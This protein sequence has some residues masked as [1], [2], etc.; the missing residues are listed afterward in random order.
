[1]QPEGLAATE[2]H[3]THKPQKQQALTFVLV[4]GAWADAAFWDRTAEALRKQ[5]HTVYAPEYAGHGSLYNPRVTHD[6][7]ADSVVKYIKDKRLKHFILVGHSFGGSVIQKVAEQV[8]ERIQ[9]LVFW[10]AFVVPDGQSVAEQFPAPLR[11][12]FQQLLDAS[13]NHT[14][15]LPFPVFRDTFVNTATLRQA[16]DIYRKVKPEPGGPLFEP[17]ELKTFY[18]LGMIPKSYLFLT[19]DIALP[20][21]PFGFHPSQSSHLG[22]YRLIVGKGDHMTSAFVHPTYLAHK[23][24][25]ASRD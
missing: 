9:R 16:K 14:I 4:H 17:L 25:E 23:L 21:T 12:A 19:S 7:I 5:G 8:P 10:D 15:N 11:Q 2:M 22:Q 20:Q 24:Y 1:M 13:G 6:Q 3:N 18:Q